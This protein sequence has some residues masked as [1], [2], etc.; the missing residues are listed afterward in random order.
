MRVERGP[1]ERSA[2]Q[3]TVGSRRENPVKRHRL[4]AQ[5]LGVAAVIFAAVV[6]GPA[7]IPGAGWLGSGAAWAQPRPEI[8]IPPKLRDGGANA[9]AD[10][11]DVI[12]DAAAPDDPTDPEPADPSAATEAV[13]IA[14]PAPIG[15]GLVLV[16]R[17]DWP[18]A[19]LA[20]HVLHRL[21]RE[22]YDCQTEIVDADP[23]EVLQA[24]LDPSEPIIAAPGVRSSAAKAAGVAEGALLFDGAERAGWYVTPRFAAAHPEIRSVPQAMLSSQRFA[25]GSGGRPKLHICPRGWECWDENRLLAR[26]YGADARF[27]LSAPLSGEALIASARSAVD[28]R[29]PWIGYLWEPS[30]IVV[31]LRMVRLDGGGVQVCDGDGCRPPFVLDP[32][33]T[34]FSPALADR[35]PRVARFLSRFHLPAAAWTEAMVWRRENDASVALTAAFLLGEHRASL[36]AQMDAEAGRRFARRNPSFAGD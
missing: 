16:A 5:W 8:R 23:S 11:A 22:G 9:T 33:I 4:P 34:A 24:M 13:V 26:D 1:S 6:D 36:L 15:C 28:E 35:A 19:A 3:Q 12:P 29:R 25:D 20:A 14:E 27:D 31:E 18:A 17:F 32:Q 7:A 30:E 10:A 21:L 2:P